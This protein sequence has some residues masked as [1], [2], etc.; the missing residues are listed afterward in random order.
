MGH[1]DNDTFLILFCTFRYIWR[2]EGS[3]KF[4]LAGRVY[5]YMS[6][7]TTLYLLATYLIFLLF[8][9]T[10]QTYEISDLGLPIGTEVIL[11]VAV[12]VPLTFLFLWTKERIFGHYGK[13]LISR[14]S[15]K[16]NRRKKILEGTLRELLNTVAEVDEADVDRFYKRAYLIKLKIE[17]LDQQIKEI[18]EEFEFHGSLTLNVITQPFW[19]VLIIEVFPRVL[20]FLRKLV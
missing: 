20:D 7:T 16:Y 3:I 13:V 5:T 2:I 6:S 4:V 8:E 1:S 17:F 12:L 11:F 15:E 19:I 9:D 18:E 10:L 14:K